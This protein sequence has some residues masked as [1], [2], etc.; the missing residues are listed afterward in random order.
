MDI[1]D[2]MDMVDRSRIPFRPLR[3]SRGPFTKS[4][5][6]TASIPLLRLTACF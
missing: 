5:P 1:V 6:S 2:V 4:I 3:P